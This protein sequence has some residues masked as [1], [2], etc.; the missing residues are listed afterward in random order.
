[1]LIN[2][3]YRDS[4]PIY[5]QIVDG[6]RKLLIAGVIKADEKLPSVRDLSSSMAIN[7]NTIQRAYR[8]LEAEGYI[9]SIAGKGSFAAPVSDVDEKRKEEMLKKLGEACQEL[10]FMGVGKE[11]I[12]SIVDEVYKNSEKTD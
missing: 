1:M 10:C 7:P 6:M 11:T 9:Y 2:I 5:E 4:R 12:D 3:N 8:E